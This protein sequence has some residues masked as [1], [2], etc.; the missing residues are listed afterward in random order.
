MADVIMGDALDI[1]QAHG[2]HR[3]GA[4][5][6]LNLA[7]FIDAKYQGMVG[8]I[9]VKADDVPHLFDEERIGGEFEATTSVRRYGKRLKHTMH[10]GF[11]NAAVVGGLANTPM[12]S[13]GRLAG[14][15]A[16][17]QDGNLLIGNAAGPPRPQ[18]IVQT[19]HTLLQETLSPLAHR[20]LGPAQTLSN[21]GIALALGRPQHYLS[22]SDEGMRQRTRSRPTLQL[23]AFVHSQIEGG[24]GASGEH[25]AAYRR[26]DTIAGYLWDTT[27]AVS[28]INMVRF[29]RSD[30]I[31]HFEERTCSNTGVSNCLRNQHECKNLWPASLVCSYALLQRC[32]RKSSRTQAEAGSSPSPATRAIAATS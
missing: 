1:A 18:L 20:G 32:P 29:V 3:L 4:V 11:G 15:G 8:R 19:R 2:Q 14:E 31:L 25:S 9:Q 17:E 28:G 27:L 13:T 12:G 5:Q 7:L 6:G 26:L 22:A 24:F 23:C 21:L 30:M 10:G 16:F